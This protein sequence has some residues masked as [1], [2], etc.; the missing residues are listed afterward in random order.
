M[1]RWKPQAEGRAPTPR[2]SPASAA[3]RPH[4]DGEGRGGH[5]DAEPRRRA[6]PPAA[7]AARAAPARRPAGS[8]SSSGSSQVAHDASVTTPATS[9]STPGEQ[10]GEV[11][12][13]VAGLG[14]ADQL[15]Q[16]ARRRARC[17]APPR[18]RPRRRS[19]RTARVGDADRPDERAVVEVVDVERVHQNGRRRRSRARRVGRRRAPP[20]QPDRG[21]ADDGERDER[22]EVTGP[23]CR[24]LRDVDARSSDAGS[25]APRPSSPPSPAASRRAARRGRA[26]P[27]AR[28]AGRAASA[29][30]AS[31]SCAATG[32]RGRSKNVISHSRVTYA[33]VTATVSS[34]TTRTSQPAQAQ[35][36]PSC[37]DAVSSA[38][39][40]TASLEKKPASGGTPASAASPSVIVAKV[41]GI[42]RRSPPMSGIR[43]VPT[44]WMT[45]PAARNSSALNAAWVSR[46]NVGGDRRA[47]RERGQHVGELADRRVGEHPLDVVLGE[48]GQRGAEHRDGGDH[49]HHGQR[50]R[51]EQEHVVEP[52]DQVDARRRPS[53]RRGSAR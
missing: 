8:A 48:R 21:G 43:L 16:P 37:M 36:G 31:G 51:G 44:A 13:H 2:R 1:P 42:S 19:S 22:A 25:P 38:A 9:R 34:P 17:R 12:L 53:S 28:R 7:A 23:M 49:R 32:L 46:W 3:T 33:A 39:P 5:R 11:G 27:S 14:P 41:T 45:E 26:A 40:S 50:R 35:A 10:P 24:S 15:G 29:S 18:R 4:R 47:D 6:A 20:D 52:G 30:P